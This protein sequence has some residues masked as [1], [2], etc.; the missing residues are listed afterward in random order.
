MINAQY[1]SGNVLQI[2]GT[3]Q[4]AGR[5]FTVMPTSSSGTYDGPLIFA[6]YGITAPERQWDDYAG[7]DVKGKAVVVF[8]HG[9]WENSG[10]IRNF[11][12]LSSF[13]MKVRNAKRHGARA[14]LFVVDSNNHLNEDLPLVS[15][16]GE[17]SDQD[18]GI[19]C[20]YVSLQFVRPLF[21]RAGKDN[22]HRSERHR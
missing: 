20:M 4:R 15:S 2:E 19:L 7:I 17:P 16:S 6:G 1:G 8:W 11:G 10:S 13:E 21:E 9:P 14:I 22:L 18:A 12:Y 3:P 5:D